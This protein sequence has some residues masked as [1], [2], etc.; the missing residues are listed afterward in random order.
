MKNY[1]L[2][3]FILVLNSISICGANDN[4]E[5]FVVTQSATTTSALSARQKAMVFARNTLAT[6]VNGKIKNTTESYVYNNT[7]TGKLADE[8]LTETKTVASIL[9]QNVEVADET[10]VKEKKEKYTVYITLRLKKSEVLHALCKHLSES[11]KTKVT[12]KKENFTDLWEKEN[13]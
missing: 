5:Y 3:L 11:P 1:L 8:F 4:R 9:L 2:S 12:F 7:E 6:I 13:K 10:V